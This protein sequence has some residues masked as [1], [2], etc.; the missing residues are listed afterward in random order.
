MSE[1]PSDTSTLRVLAV[2]GPT[3]V[4]KSDV[5]ERLALADDGEIVS[6][7]AMQ[8]YR[9]MDIGT[10]KPSL[11]KRMVPYHCVDLVDPGTPYSAALFQR[12]ARE[13]IAGCAARGRL[14]IVCGGT[15]LYVRAALDPL[16]FP[17]PAERDADTTR[18]RYGALAAELGPQGLHALLAD[19]DPKSAALIHPNNVRRVLRALEM[20]DEGVSYAT[21]ACGFSERTSIFAAAFLGLTMERRALYERIDRR[22]DSM[23][24]AGLL[25]EVELLVR[26][27]FREALTAAQAIGYKEFVPVLDGALS[28]DE[29]VASVKMATRRYA[30][31]QLTWF[32]ADERIRWVDVTDLSPAETLAAAQEALR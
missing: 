19:R 31:R 14:P 3:C 7:D 18:E 4:G 21:Q 26:S 30:K 13:A 11:T 12:D 17:P 22:V 25:A 1:H 27:G 15:G 8:V 2:V 32:R 24:A 16:S 20:A 29:A 5:A 23:M 10:A 28:V 6:A 9:G